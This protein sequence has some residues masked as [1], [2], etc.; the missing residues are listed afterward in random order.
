MPQLQ[1]RLQVW[2]RS[3]PWPGSSVCHRMVK[4][5]KSVNYEY[6][7][8]VLDFIALAGKSSIQSIC[9]LSKIKY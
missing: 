6:Y 3:D 9:E 7:E 2:L 1:Y 4:K 8:T 5:K